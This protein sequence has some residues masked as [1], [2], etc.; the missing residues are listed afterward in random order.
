MNPLYLGL[1][2]AAAGAGVGVGVRWASVRLARLEE[3]EPGSRPWQVLGPPALA[4][5]LFGVLGATVGLQPLLLIRSL[6]AA[7][8]VHVIFF[9]FE[10]RLVLN[11]VIVPAMAAA[12]VLSLV[13]PGL[14]WKLSLVS[15]LGAGLFFLLMAVIGSLAMGGEALGMGD[16]K[17][18]AFIGFILGLSPDGAT[19]RALI[20]GVFLGGVVAVGLLVFRARKMREA[21]AYGPFLSAGALLVLLQSAPR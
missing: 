18:A 11:R 1:V 20:L 8:L 19:P 10:H 9:D 14:G 2:W 12:I 16:V 13:T 6:W 15:G 21:F 3:L 5:L 7:V 4:A 17:L